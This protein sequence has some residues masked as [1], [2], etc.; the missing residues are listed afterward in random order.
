MSKVEEVLEDLETNHREVPMTVK[1]PKV[2]GFRVWKYTFMIAKDGEVEFA[3]D[4]R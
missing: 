4:N 2:W 3:D 1:A